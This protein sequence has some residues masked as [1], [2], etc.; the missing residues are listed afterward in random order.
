MACKLLRKLILCSFPICVELTY[1]IHIYDNLL[2]HV[3]TLIARLYIVLLT[4]YMC[5]HL[6]LG[7]AKVK[8]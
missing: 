1:D 2:L 7:G 3:I 6:T 5:W 4:K 8:G